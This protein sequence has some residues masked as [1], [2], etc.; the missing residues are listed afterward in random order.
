MI[1]KKFEWTRQDEDKD[2][3]NFW[4]KQKI[5]DVLEDIKNP[6]SLFYK[7]NLRN[8]DKIKTS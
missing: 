2:D 6:K 7:T 5:K 1:V 8:I 4:N 3:L